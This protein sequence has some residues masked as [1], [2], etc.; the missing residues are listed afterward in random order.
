MPKYEFGVQMSCEGCSGAV[1]RALGRVEG[2]NSKDVSLEKQTVI[3][4]AT[5]SLS[6]QTVH[7]TIAKTGKKITYGKTIEA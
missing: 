5:P 6:Y 1:N 4:D 7:D 3:V 2:I